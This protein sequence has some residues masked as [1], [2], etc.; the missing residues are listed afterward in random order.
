[1]CIPSPPKV[2]AT[3]TAT[4]VQTS[5]DTLQLGT[6]ALANK[7]A[8]IFGRLALTGGS[9]SA[10]KVSKASSGTASGST[11]SSTPG[12]TMGLP[13]D[14]AGQGVYGGIISSGEIGG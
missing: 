14:Y 3:S 7:G 5:A 8:G 10:R 2:G 9:R 1:M 13:S 11:T 6:A 4:P 12:G